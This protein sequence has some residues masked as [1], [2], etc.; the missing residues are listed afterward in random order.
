MAKDPLS[1]LSPATHRVIAAAL[2][3]ERANGKPMSVAT[4]TRLCERTGASLGACLVFVLGL[5]RDANTGKLVRLGSPEHGSINAP[6]VEIEA[7]LDWSEQH[8]D[9]APR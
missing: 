6:D 8:G 5:G 4:I 9:P 1:K 3:H 7:A 2:L